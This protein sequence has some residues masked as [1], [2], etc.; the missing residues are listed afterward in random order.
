MASQS[1]QM[2]NAPIGVIQASFEHNRSGEANCTD[3]G[4]VGKLEEEAKAK[5]NM[6]KKKTKKKQKK[7]Q[8]MEYWQ[9]ARA[10]ICFDKF[11]W[12]LTD[13]C[14][15][16]AWKVRF[17]Y[18]VRMAK[19]RPFWN[20]GC[21]GKTRNQFDSEQQCQRACEPTM[22]MT[23]TMPDRML[24]AAQN[25]E[26]RPKHENKKHGKKA[27]AIITTTTKTAIGG[28]AISADA[29]ADGFD[30]SYRRACNNG[31]RWQRKWFFDQRTGFCRYFWYDGCNGR[32]RNIFDGLKEC[33]DLC[34]GSE[35]VA[36]ADLEKPANLVERLQNGDIQYFESGEEQ[37]K[38]STVAN[39]NNNNDDDRVPTNKS[40][41]QSAHL[42]MDET[43][44]TAFRYNASGDGDGGGGGGKAAR[45][46]A[47]LCLLEEG[48][49]CQS[50]VL[51]LENDGVER[52]H[53]ERPW[54][55]GK[56]TYAWFFTLER[57]AAWM[58]YNKD[59]DGIPERMMRVGGTN[60]SHEQ[61]NKGERTTMQ[62]RDAFSS[63]STSSGTLTLRQR[64]MNATHTALVPIQP[65]GRVNGTAV[66]I[67]LIEVVPTA[68]C[69]QFC[70]PP[71]T[72]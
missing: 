63:T 66:W 29:C 11:D 34:M 16:H 53:Q 32:S 17:F 58:A 62:Q 22:S 31:R 60:E 10:K 61:N 23:M 72:I 2:M 41:V 67:D 37:R 68:K 65:F 69:Q 36:A 27:D 13:T 25:D 5:A 52:C 8:K 43:E 54:L 28:T 42:D 48:G 44:C 33:M 30:E 57:H 71:T 9:K 55:K 12:N 19:C 59:E 6:A 26:K 38:E 39:A 3:N 46:S 14:G 35:R 47:F 50:T 64:A 40:Y 7:K 21:A 56:H 45:L 51:L 24:E 18:D 70:A 1:E 4:V 49:G 15:H 20:D